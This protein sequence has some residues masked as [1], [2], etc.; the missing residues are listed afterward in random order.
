MIYRVENAVHDRPHP[1]WPGG[2][3]LWERVFP[4]C[5]ERV[6]QEMPRSRVPGQDHLKRSQAVVAPGRRRQPEVL[7]SQIGNIAR[8]EV[9]TGHTFSLCNHWTIT[10]EGIIK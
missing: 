4:E 5:A 8:G 10:L 6:P 1:S 3:R 7:R 9:S 2:R